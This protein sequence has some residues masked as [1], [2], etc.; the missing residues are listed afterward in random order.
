MGEVLG[1]K[2]NGT[3][4]GGVGKDKCWGCSRDQ[5]GVKKEED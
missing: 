1:L 2:L 5:D 3:G 4:A